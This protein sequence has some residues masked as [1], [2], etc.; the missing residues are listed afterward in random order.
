MLK[1]KSNFRKILLIFFGV[2]IVLII[3][4]MIFIDPLLNSMVKPK[5][6]DY[7]NKNKKITLEFDKLDYSL[8]TNSLSVLN[9][10]FTYSDSSASGSDSLSVQTPSI[11][12]SGINW[13]KLVFGSYNSFNE[14][15][16]TEPFIFIKR[17]HNRGVDNTTNPVDLPWGKRLQELLPEELNI[18]ELTINSENVSARE[19]RRVVIKFIYHRNLNLTHWVSIKGATV[20]INRFKDTSKKKEKHKKDS[21]HQTAMQSWGL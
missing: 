15:T 14:I 1:T 9:S 17:T 3:A 18:P 19:L 11:S 20:K 5:L 6:L 13:L 2:V 7:A 16:I 12:F 4:I 21:L 10:K 8:F